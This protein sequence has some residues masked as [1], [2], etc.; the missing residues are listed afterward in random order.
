MGKDAAFHARRP[1]ASAYHDP[2]PSKWSCQKAE[3]R[4][5]QQLSSMTRIIESGPHYLYNEAT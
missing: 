3:I 2:R 5:L 1:A 4:N